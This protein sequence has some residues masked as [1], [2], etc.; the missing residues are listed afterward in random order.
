MFEVEALD[1]T[2]AD[3]CIM[4]K[5]KWKSIPGRRSRL[6]QCN[7]RLTGANGLSLYVVSKLDLEPVVKQ[8]PQHRIRTS[9][10]VV[11]NLNT[12]FILSRSAL[13]QLLIISP[14]FLSVIDYNKTCEAN[15]VKNHHVN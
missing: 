10:I 6:R 9:V 12:P 14:D 7:M 2:G 4:D 15:A 1:D 11:R 13:K 5:T 3:A 8:L